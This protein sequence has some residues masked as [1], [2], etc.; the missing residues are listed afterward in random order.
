[1]C[2]CVDIPVSLPLAGNGE[3]RFAIGVAAATIEVSDVRDGV[4]PEALF[5][6]VVS[7]ARDVLDGELAGGEVVELPSL[8]SVVS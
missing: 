8:D 1:M 3:V 6:N 2:A 4:F 7:A 5:D